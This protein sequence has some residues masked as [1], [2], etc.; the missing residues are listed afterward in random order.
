MRRLYLIK[1]RAR[2]LKA[3]ALISWKK[4][5]MRQKDMGV[6]VTPKKL[7]EPSEKKYNF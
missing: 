1:P 2:V 7:Q 6:N 5:W 3:M 4:G